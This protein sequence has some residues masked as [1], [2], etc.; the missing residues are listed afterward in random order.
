MIPMQGLNGFF[1][2]PP[3]E[4]KSTKWNNRISDK[5]ETLMVLKVNLLIP[6][7][8]NCERRCKSNI[9]Y[10]KALTRPTC[11]GNF[12]GRVRLC[13]IEARVR[14]YSAFPFNS[15]SQSRRKSASKKYRNQ[16]ST[17]HF[18]SKL[19]MIGKDGTSIFLDKRLMRAS[20]SS[21][22]TISFGGGTCFDGRVT[23]N[24][25]AGIR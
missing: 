6:V 2:R 10:I 5:V 9:K 24:C 1:L 17:Y 20:M 18:Q 11:V 21:V 22:I 15:R 14:R 8:E 19:P 25:F 16:F 3:R 12:I 13:K 7:Q 4:V 23:S